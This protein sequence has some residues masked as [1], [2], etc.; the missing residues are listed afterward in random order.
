VI[1]GVEQKVYPAPDPDFSSM[2]MAD[3]LAFI[4]ESDDQIKYAREKGA[5]ELFV[6]GLCDQRAR[7]AAQLGRLNGNGTT[8]TLSDDPIAATLQAAGLSEI[9][10]GASMAAVEEAVRYLALL[11]ADATVDDI[12]RA[13]VR[14]A[15]LKKLGEI[16]ISA[17]ARLLDAA[18]QRQQTQSDTGLILFSDPE[19]WPSVVDGAGLL[20]D[21]VNLIRR[22]V[23]VS[24]DAAHATAL[25]IMHAWTLEAFDISPLLVITSATKRCGKTTLLEA[26]GMLA[27][28][29]LP[30]SNLTTATLFRA[31][32][33]FKPVMLIDEADSFMGEK[34]E[35]RGV[36]NSGHRR[37]SAFV[38]RTV[39]VGDEH[40]PKVFSTWGAK[41]IASIGKLAGTIED[42]SIII[43]MRR[44]A[45]GE[46]VEKFRT[47]I[48]KSFADP[49]RRQAYR[50]ACDFIPTLQTITPKEPETL[51]DRAADNWRPLLAIAQL[52][53]EEWP[54]RA[55]RAAIELS[56][57][58]DEAEDSAVVDLLREFKELFQSKDRITSADLAEYLGGQVDKR[59]A[60]WRHGK[61]ITQRQVARLLAPLKIKSGTIRVGV[62]ETPK[63]YMRD[64]FD[65][66][67]ARYIP[68]ISL[69]TPPPIRHTDTSEQNQVDMAKIDPPQ[70]GHVADR[71]DGLSSGN[72]R[73][74][75][76]VADRKGGSR[77]KGFD[78]RA[79][80]QDDDFEDIPR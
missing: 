25:W 80:E 55:R 48:Y 8:A 73:D 44:R 31:V 67:F 4:A 72:H 30:A 64:W 74:V 35:L 29:P 5:E 59:W 38:I 47:A 9:Q 75:A 11:L 45:P 2:T 62:T 6:I 51:N 49:L 69:D 61:P 19:P 23:V 66:A 34:E 40:E 10:N 79:G 46:R 78:W 15:A 28:R 14:E 7:A 33:K 65:D 56:Q 17:P 24:H 43:Q 32:E 53:G 16:G 60:E 71:K 52:C 21:I 3:L 50:W 36:I 57:E 39:P 27:P 1:N 42:R 63:G 76:D 37:S 41:A 77:S 58:I 22:Y 18:L 68:P 20:S 13:T 70:N 12:R 26:I 54:A